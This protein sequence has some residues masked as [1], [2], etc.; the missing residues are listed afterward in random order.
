MW[1]NSQCIWFY[2][3]ICYKL[4]RLN[5]WTWWTILKLILNQGVNLFIPSLVKNN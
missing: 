5:N 4:K 1:G 2:I 3:Q